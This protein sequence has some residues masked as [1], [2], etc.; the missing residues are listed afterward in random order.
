MGER[1]KNVCNDSLR[2][3]QTYAKEIEA[4]TI[5]ETVRKS[6]FFN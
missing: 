1:E 6:W 3:A 2:F 4:V 5:S